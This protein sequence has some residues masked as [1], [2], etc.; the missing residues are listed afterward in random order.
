VAKT[1]LEKG[2]DPNLA[3]VKGMTPL[4]AAV[5]MH[6]IPTTFGRPDPPPLVRAGAV[7]AVTLLLAHGA[8]P[9]LTLKAPIIKRVYNPGDG[10]FPM[11]PPRSCARRAGGTWR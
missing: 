4:Y 10:V 7:D 3:D 9:D 2:A 8:K 6:T 1:L 5:D 11:A